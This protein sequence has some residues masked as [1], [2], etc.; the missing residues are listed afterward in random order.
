MIWGSGSAP[1]FKGERTYTIEKG[2]S[3]DECQFTM[4][5]HLKGMMLPLIK[6]SLPDFRPSFEQFAADLK[7]EA[8]KD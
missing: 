1:M 7:K 4:V 3:D 6:K 8:E 5:E 2:S